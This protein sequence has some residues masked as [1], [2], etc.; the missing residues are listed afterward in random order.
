MLFQSIGKKGRAML[1]ALMQSGGIF[2][3]MLLILPQFFGL[4]G[5]ELAQPAAYVAA[6]LFSIPLV[7]SFLSSLK[8]EYEE[9]VQFRP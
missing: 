7:L 9:D 3:P 4:T 6:G 5:L 2:I 1:L 8:S